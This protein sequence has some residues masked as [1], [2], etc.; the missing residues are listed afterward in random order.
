MID[1]GAGR[2]PYGQTECSM[3]L[4]DCGSYVKTVRRIP[5]Y[6]TTLLPESA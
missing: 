1:F 4:G 6:V 5:R 3:E 2:L